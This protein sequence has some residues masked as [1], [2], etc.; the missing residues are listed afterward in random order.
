MLNV[1]FSLQ[2]EEKDSNQ[3]QF[4]RMPYKRHFP[5]RVKRSSVQQHKQLPRKPRGLRP[6]RRRVAPN[7]VRLRRS[8]RN[9]NRVLPYFPGSS[10]Q[11]PRSSNYIEQVLKKTITSPVRH[12]KQNPRKPSLSKPRKCVEKPRK[13]VEEPRKCIEKPLVL[14]EKVDIP[15]TAVVKV[16]QPKIEMPKIVIDE[17]KDVV[18]KPKIVIEKPKIVVEKP[19]LVLETPAA[20][21]TSK[22]PL[23]IAK[24][25]ELVTPRR[26]VPRRTKWGKR[27]RKPKTEAKPCELCAEE[28][29]YRCSKCHSAVYCS[30]K[31]Y[32]AHMKECREVKRRKTEDKPPP[33]IVLPDVDLANS[34]VSRD[35]LCLLE[36]SQVVRER[37]TKEIKD[38]VLQV[39]QSATPMKVLEKTRETNVHFS[40]FSSLL[41]RVICN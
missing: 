16:E 21:S 12:S 32:K 4:Q 8:V 34:L 24:P 31:C 17:P 20:A 11:L 36:K 37:L 33:P 1:P 35:Q 3:E 19:R 10:A 14:V 27:R 30:V 15:G 18:E 7:P 28:S 22:P 6:R 9:R 39:A 29:K 40:R 13:C 2:D 23:N 26:Y 25:Q 38:L 41:L 5:K